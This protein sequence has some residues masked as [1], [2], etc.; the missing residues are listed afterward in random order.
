MGDA[1][2]GDWGVP[3]PILDDRHTLPRLCCPLYETV[4]IVCD[5][6]GVKGRK[7]TTNKTHRAYL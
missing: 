6:M 2:S 3:T 1:Y 7:A 5:G 4:A